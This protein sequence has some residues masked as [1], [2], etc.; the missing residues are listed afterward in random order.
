M[1]KE[2]I[3]V[4]IKT[5][6]SRPFKALIDNELEALQAIVG[7][8]IEIL[9]VCSDKKEVLLIVNEEGKIMNLPYNFMTE[10]DFIAGTAIF[11]GA[12]GEDLDDCP[13][14]VKQVERM[15]INGGILI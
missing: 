10:Y 8:Y 13:V 15:I 2:Q 9:P 4:I 6:N 12:D 1:K 7:G 5:P 3:S 11:C 14:T